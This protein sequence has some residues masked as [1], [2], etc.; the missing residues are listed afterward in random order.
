MPDS[1]ALLYSKVKTHIRRSINTGLAGSYVCVCVCL[2]V[3]GWQRYHFLWSA[4]NF[5]TDEQSALIEV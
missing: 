1:T 5:H 2:C 3:C 4:Y